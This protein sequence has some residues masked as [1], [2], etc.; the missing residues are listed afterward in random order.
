M[1]SVRIDHQ[2]RVE[3]PDAATLQ[4]LGVTDWPIWTK[5]A[6]T[7][8]WEYDEPEACYF[9]DGEVVVT[10]K[11]GQVAIRKGDLVTF[12]KGLACTWH[13]KQAVRKHYRFGQAS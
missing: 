7:F 3:R 13:V 1:S 2:V 12:Q 4:R 11:G 10:W 6:S 9:L 8:D 5:E